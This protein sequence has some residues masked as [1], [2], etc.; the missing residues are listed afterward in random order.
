MLPLSLILG[1]YHFSLG[2]V[3]LDLH[4]YV[5]FNLV[6]DF[7]LEETTF[8][9]EQSDTDP[10]PDDR[11]DEEDDYPEHEPIYQPADQDQDEEEIS[12]GTSQKHKV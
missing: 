11:W 10:N 9:E 4:W 12:T 7:C 6:I 2:W 3:D 5:T 8:D 1:F